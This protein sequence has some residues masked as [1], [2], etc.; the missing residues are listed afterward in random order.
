MSK[1]VNIPVG[2]MDLD[3]ARR[4]L[5]RFDSRLPPDVP[6]KVVVDLLNNL[7]VEFRST[8]EGL[9]IEGRLHVNLQHRNGGNFTIH[10]KGFSQALRYAREKVAKM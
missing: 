3:E 5:S 2:R 9:L 1:K 10:R 8:K 4:T 7:G 6:Y